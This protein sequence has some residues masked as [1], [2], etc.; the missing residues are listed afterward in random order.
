MAQRPSEG[1]AKAP[2]E[3]ELHAGRFAF[4]R[5]TGHF[6]L[7]SPEGAEAFRLLLD[8]ANVD[9]IAQRLCAEFGADPQTGLRDAE[10]FAARLK[11]L[12]L[13]TGNRAAGTGKA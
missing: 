3:W 4:N 9:E 10:Q 8:G 7:L 2:S 1:L 11:A 12:H 5:A 13:P 6:F